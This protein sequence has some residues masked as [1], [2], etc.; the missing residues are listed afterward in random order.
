MYILNADQYEYY[1]LEDFVNLNVAPDTEETIYAL[2]TYQ[3]EDLFEEIKRRTALRSK[4]AQGAKGESLSEEYQ[5]TEDERDVFIKWMRKRSAKIFK[6]I[7]GYSK[8]INSAFRFNVNFGDPEFSSLV[9]S[10]SP[11]GLT[12]TDMSLDMLTNEYAGMKLVI[13]SPGLYENQERTI[14]SNTDTAFVI[15]SA[16]TGDVSGLEY[17][18]AAQTEKHILIYT[19]MNIL[20][21]D[22][23][24]LEGIDSLFE[25][26]FVRALTA[27]WF[28]I[29]RFM[30]DFQI[31][32]T[33]LKKDISDLRMHF[34]QCMTQ[35]RA[36]P[37]FNDNDTGLTT[38]P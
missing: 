21:F 30:D 16:F 35:A 19:L 17:I 26:C 7:S 38:I 9:S 4:L 12:I 22:T 8:A 3:I 27:E 18:V 2:F 29:N 5:L 31:E 24:M 10:V 33:E 6:E 14:V 13:T 25:E 20:H 23:N 15:D 32:E 28:L 34:F 11:D 36:T 1:S 37:F